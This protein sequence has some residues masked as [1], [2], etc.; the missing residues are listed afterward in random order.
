MEP[1]ARQADVALYHLGN[2]PLHREIYRRALEKPGVVVLHDAV[3]HHFFLGSLDEREYVEEFV[4]NYGEWSRRLAA[5]LWRGRA[6]SASDPR[7]FDYPM[8]KRV[9]E[10]RARW[11][12]TIRGAARMVREHAP[13][14][15]MDEIPHLF[16]P[17]R[18]ASG[19]G[20]V[21]RLRQSL[22][23]PTEHFSSGVRLPAGIQAPARRAAGL[24]GASR[25]AAG[26]GAAGGGRFRIVRP[27]SAPPA[28]LLSAGRGILRV[29]YLAERD[30]WR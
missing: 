5:E 25:R 30:F 3:L 15:A 11:W 1:G 7:Y 18:N 24:R 17:P 22:G 2:N 6:R 14:A 13:N 8:L 29:G 20:E 19:S 16:A 28:P 12:Y 27:A 4:Y 9:A 10:R 26:H 21:L 23:V